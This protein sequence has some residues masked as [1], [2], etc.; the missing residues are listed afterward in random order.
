MAERHQAA[1]RSSFSRDKKFMN[2][3]FRLL[4]THLATLSAEKAMRR[5]WTGS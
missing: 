5:K 4:S 3:H 1:K 2:S